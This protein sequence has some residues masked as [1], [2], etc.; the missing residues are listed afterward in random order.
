MSTRRYVAGVVLPASLALASV[1]GCGAPAPPGPE[2][3]VGPE[4]STEW[5]VATAT[6]WISRARP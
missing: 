5:D 6:S 1:L 2:E 4:G 3:Y